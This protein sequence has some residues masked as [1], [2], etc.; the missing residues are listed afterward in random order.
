MQKRQQDLPSSTRTGLRLVEPTPR[1]AG[2]SEQTSGRRIRQRSNPDRRLP[3]YSEQNRL[4]AHPHHPGPHVRA[5]LQRRSRLR[6][7]EK[8]N[9]WSNIQICD[10]PE[11]TG[12]GIIQPDETKT[13]IKKQEN[14]QGF[15]MDKLQSYITSPWPSLH[16]TS[17]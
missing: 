2:F 7:A 5:T 6:N 9:T 15:L 10:N 11:T 16:G 4:A 8:K 12:I 14:A 3:T 17:C 13:Y 1:R